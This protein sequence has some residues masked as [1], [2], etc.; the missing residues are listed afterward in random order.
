[1]VERIWDSDP[2]RYAAAEAERQMARDKGNGRDPA[3]PT[4]GVSLSDFY[5]YMP[6]HTY[7]FAPACEM[8][9]KDSVNARIPPISVDKGPPRNAS[10]WLDQ[11]RPVEQM[12]WAPGLPMIIK[13]RLVSEGGWIERRGVSCFNLYRPPRIK[14][15]ETDQAGRWLD[16]LE[17]VYPDNA[18]H[19]LKWLAHRV[20]RPQEKINHALVLGG[21]QGIGKDTLL[22]PLKLAVGPWN[23]SEVSPEQIMGRFNG[24]LKSVVLRINE[25][26]D[27]GDS[28]RF[29]LY[30]H[31]KVFTAAPPDVLRVDEKNL[32]EHSVLNVC[33]V[34]ITTNYKTNGIYLPA[35]DR[36]HYVAWSD[37]NKDDL[38]QSY[39]DDMWQWY[40]NGGYGHVTALLADCDLSDFNP[41]AP[42]P[43]TTAF[44][45]IVHASRNPED[46][47][48][49]DA[50][51]LLEWPETVTLEQVAG[52]ATNP[53]NDWLRD[54]RN[55][56]LIPYRL[57]ECGY[58]AVRNV[59]AKDGLWKVNGKRQAIYAKKELSARDRSTLAAERAGIR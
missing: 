34:I 40:E 32:R 7:I 1:M 43:K 33:G 35:D 38:P 28:D 5:A 47:E 41:K 45:E 27:L 22:A 3:P 57:D 31:L 4:K 49:A 15:G 44:W 2:E 10:I 11:N 23:F 20:Q 14:P 59:G 18:D 8:W 37:L 13:D 53:F 39:W 12:T 21:D 17:K 36:R 54:R 30:E 46:A 16:H 42:P 55:S 48:L 19:I 6:Q 52:A 9:P 50:L 58:V 24:F 51:D 29:K 25:A 56:R 26:R